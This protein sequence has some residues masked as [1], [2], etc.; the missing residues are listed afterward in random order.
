MIANPA[1]GMPS[2]LRHLQYERMLATGAASKFYG[3]MASV[4]ALLMAGPP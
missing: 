4:C 1:Q 2:H 3:G